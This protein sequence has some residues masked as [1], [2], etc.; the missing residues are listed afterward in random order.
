MVHCCHKYL[1]KVSSKVTSS[2]PLGQCMSMK[3]FSTACSD[4]LKHE[5]LEWHKSALQLC[6]I[7]HHM[8]S[9]MNLNYPLD[10]RITCLAGVI[11]IVSINIKHKVDRF[12]S[13]ATFPKLC[14]QAVKSTHKF[15]APSVKL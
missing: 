2:K 4:K 10:S 14:N 3:I 1:T 5:T 7:K 9:R 8:V 12:K 15:C 13:S 6:C 11:V